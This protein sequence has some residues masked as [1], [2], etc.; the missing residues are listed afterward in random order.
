MRLFENLF[1]KKSKAKEERKAGAAEERGKFMPKPDIPIDEKFIIN[2]TENGG[3]FLYCSDRREVENNFYNILRE[4]NWKDEVCCFDEKLENSF[5]GFNL[6]FTTNPD[7][8]F[9]LLPCEFLIADSGSLLMTS[10]QIGERK[11]ADLPYNFVVFAYTSQLIDTPDDGLRIINYRKQNLPTNISSIKNF[12][13][14]ANQ[15]GHF[16]SYGSVSK[17]LYLLLLEDL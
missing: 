1:G 11:L 3:K 6:E 17:N 2:F 5:G 4:N 7:A 15:E 10:N 16:M 14:D 8:D 9:C 13:E 12:K